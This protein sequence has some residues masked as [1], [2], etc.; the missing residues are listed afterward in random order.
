MLGIGLETSSAL[1]PQESPP[2]PRARPAARAVRSGGSCRRLRIVLRARA[3]LAGFQ[4][5]PQDRVPGRERRATGKVRGL[6]RNTESIRNRRFD[7]A[8]VG[9]GA[10]GACAAW[11]AVLRGYSVVLIE[12]NDFASGTSANSFKFVHG[13]VRY[14]QHLDFARLRASCAERSALLRIAPHLVRPQSIA[15]PTYGHGRNGKAL[16]G[17]GLA[18]YDLLT[19][20]RNRGIR[21]PARRIPRASFMSRH[22]LLRRFPELEPRGLTG[23]AVFADAQMYH[24]P[25]L[26]L[27]FIRSAVERG[28]EA[29]NYVEALSLVRRGDRI[30]GVIARDRL[31][32]E[33]F[34]IR[35]R[36]VVNTAGPWAEGLLAEAHGLR[37]PG[38]GV[39]SR[40]TCF[41]VDGGEESEL[42]LAIQGRSVD[43][44][45]RIGRG[46]RHLFIVPWR[47]RRL[48]GVWHIVY[49]KGPD[50]I[51]VP[52]PELAR[53]LD[54]LNA[55]QRVI[56]LRREDLRLVNAGL[57]PFGT[58]DDAGA[59]LEFGKR[60]HLVD[61]AKRHGVEGLV[62][63]IG[64]RHTM[65]RGDAARALDIVDRKLGRRGSVPDSAH[66]PLVGGDFAVFDELVRDVQDALTGEDSQGLAHELAALYGTRSLPL[67]ERGRA[68]GTLSRIAGSD[69]VGAQIA[70]AIE[71]E[72][73][74]TLADVVFRR[75]P[76]AA[77]GNPGKEV[78]LAC[79]DAMAARL[80]WSPER[81]QLELAA[82]ISRFPT[83]SH[84]GRISERHGAA[85]AE[86]QTDELD[87][88]C[89][90]R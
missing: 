15:I 19:A 82:V 42:A 68:D 65:A 50:A 81:R 67:V 85:V 86:P 87:F 21:D 71:N 32:N 18:A 59:E 75:T 28:A 52:E 49:R 38:A 12:A 83:P 56:S 33:T 80:G 58:S 45:A 79:A 70:E 51:E 8:V 6:Q 27:S 22:E 1:Q 63:L 72:M 13:G 3:R 10:F 41:V 37:I 48:V 54:E 55:S 76:L 24:P 11:E 61:S 14:L 46:A 29:A 73:A 36:V 66:E 39:Y 25:R 16:L 7:V 40:D 90:G 89:R 53:V 30:E 2:N 4:G 78:L 35:S 77:G 47:G 34:E 23:A 5:D 62:T 60:S 64:V 57:V 17:A 88:A 31:T 44:G 84:A 26:V 74:Q 20:G 69:I 9:G 43:R